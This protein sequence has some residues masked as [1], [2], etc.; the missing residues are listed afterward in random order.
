MPAVVWSRVMRSGQGFLCFPELGLGM[1]LSTPFAELA[2]AKLSKAA[3]R[4]AVL[5]GK[6][7]GSGGLVATPT[8]E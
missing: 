1:P 4:E 6:R 2:K 8:R 7:Y 5:T 3:L